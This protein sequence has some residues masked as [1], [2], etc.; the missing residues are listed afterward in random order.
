[1]GTILEYL[2]KFWKRSQCGPIS[3]YLTDNIMRNYFSGPQYGNNGWHRDATKEYQYDYCK[4]IMYKI[5]LWK[6]IQAQ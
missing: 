1:M 6:D 2:F 5:Y 4:E 3:L